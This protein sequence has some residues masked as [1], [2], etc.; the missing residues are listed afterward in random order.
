M[1]GKKIVK[2]EGKKDKEWEE[3]KEELLTVSLI[4]LHCTD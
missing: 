4:L 2:R 1:E 3:E